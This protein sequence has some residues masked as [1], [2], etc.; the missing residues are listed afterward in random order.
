MT[1][2]A[3]RLPRLLALSGLGST[4]EFFDFV[5]FLFLAS[6]I[7]ANFFPTNTPAWLADL[8]TLG[9]FA[10]GYIFR[11]LGGLVMAHFGDLYGRKKVFLFSILLMAL[12]TLGI[13]L[14]PN[15]SQIGWLAPSILLILRSLQGAAIGGE[16]P[17]AWTFLAEH[18]P[19]RNLALAC[20]FTSSSLIAGVLLAS[21]V[22]LA[23]H[24]AFTLVGMI[25]YGWRVPFAVAGLFGLL[26]AILRH[27]L[28]E[29]PVFLRARE[30]RPHRDALPLVEVVRNHKAALA[31]SVAATWTLSAVVIVTT[32]MTPFILQRLYGFEPQDALALSAF[33]APFLCLGGLFAGVMSDRLG[34]GWYLI[35]ASLPFGAANLLCYGNLGPDIGYIHLSFAMASFFNGL[36]GVNPCIMARAFPSNVRY[37]G[38]SLGYNI[39][40]AVSGGLTP[41]AMGS[42][43]ATY[44]MAHVYYLLMIGAAIAL[45]GGYTT[46]RPGSVRYGKGRDEQ[47][48]PEWA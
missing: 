45:L 4:L 38:I 47:P 30:R 26:G 34:I 28:S 29:T 16:A 22:T 32:L 13:A 18:V 5:I 25:E 41:L 17:G 44:P 37:S 19:S 6:E 31:L 15:Y 39:T 8:Q 43:F 1:D 10:A 3:T 23:A 46:W 20:A 2:A 12:S 9:I 36:V 33:G 48:E 27:W 24:S 11:P 40:F 7:S 42:L 14:V 35:L 21:L